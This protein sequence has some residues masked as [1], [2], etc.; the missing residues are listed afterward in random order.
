MWRYHNNT[1][2]FSWAHGKICTISDPIL[3]FVFEHDSQRMNTKHSFQTQRQAR[4][5]A[6]SMVS[7]QKCCRRDIR[8]WSQ[9]EHYHRATDHSFDICALP[10]N[11]AQCP[12]RWRYINLWRGTA[13]EPARKEDNESPNTTPF[14]RTF[15]YRDRTVVCATSDIWMYSHKT[16][17]FLFQEDMGKNMEAVYRQ[18]LDFLGVDQNHQTSFARVNTHKEIRFEWMRTLIGATQSLKSLLPPKRKLVWADGFDIV[19]MKHAKRPKL[20]PEFETSNQFSWNWCSIGIVGR[21]LDHW[22]HRELWQSFNKRSL[23]F[24]EPWK[25]NE[26]SPPQWSTICIHLYYSQVFCLFSVFR[27]EGT[28]VNVDTATEEP[29][30]EPSEPSEPS[31]PEA[32]P[33]DED[34][35]GDG[36]SENEGDC[37]DNDED[38]SRR[39]RRW[40]IL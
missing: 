33:A 28:E 3:I 32:D 6:S 20:D 30:A 15:V 22:K 10:A 12:W 16:D 7:F 31:Q 14:L 9:H 21:N 40:W 2:I 23:Y 1:P 24:D 39:S 19:N 13:A 37:D 8:I 36:F 38:L 5:E 11:E 26:S 27:Q 4:G 18:T 17:L 25:E 34:N 29:A 35:D